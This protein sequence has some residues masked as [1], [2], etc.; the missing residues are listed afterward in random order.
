MAPFDND[1]TDLRASSTKL[2]TGVERKTSS[3]P[4]QA[5]SGSSA[6][7]SIIPPSTAFERFPL[8]LPNPVILLQRPFFFIASANDAPI[9]PTP[10]IVIL[11][12]IILNSLYLSADGHG[13]RFQFF[14]RLFEM[15]RLEGLFS[16]GHR[17]FGVC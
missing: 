8:F 9:R 4:L 5:F 14:H 3:A 1:G 17:L 16:V 13:Y 11:S 2:P 12:N 7:E 15:L 6:K 10:K